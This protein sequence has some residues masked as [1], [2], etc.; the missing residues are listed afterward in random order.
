M[1]V[2]GTRALMLTIERIVETFHQYVCCWISVYH[3]DTHAAY[4][5]APGHLWFSRE[6]HDR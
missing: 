6:Y 4:R 2:F 5:V 3:L 1:A